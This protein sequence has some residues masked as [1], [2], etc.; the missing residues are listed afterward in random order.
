MW[1]L[2]YS[3]RV[4][5]KE[6][7]QK[8]NDLGTLSF[9]EKAK[10]WWSPARISKIAGKKK[11][12]FDPATTAPLLRELLLLNSDASM[13]ADCV[14]KFMQINHMIELIKPRL[15]ELK[16]RFAVV[17]ILDCGCGNSYLSFLLAWAFQHIWDHPVLIVGIDT[18]KKIIQQCEARAARLGLQNSLQFYSCPVK[19]FLTEFSNSDNRYHALIALHAC[20]TATDDA[21][22]LALALKTDLIAVAPCCQAE[23][24]NKWRVFSSQN[25]QHAF[26]I[27]MRSPEMRRD[28]ASSMTDAMRLLLLRGSGYE[29]QSIEFVP[30]E[31]TPKNRLLVAQRRGNYYDDALREYRQLK[32][33]LGDMGIG[34]EDALPEA[35]SNRFS[36]V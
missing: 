17:K 36:L 16:E 20:D 8:K 24:A 34:L 7:M 22:A 23:L 11:L 35:V 28:V 31:H 5:G 21:L 32:T 10:L 13:P 25:V 18:N 33:H 9:A 3:G 27:V 12:F 19:S 1:H 6:F 29:A 30:S 26:G 15:L 4:D 14:R 2:F